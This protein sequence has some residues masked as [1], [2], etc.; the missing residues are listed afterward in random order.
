MP[1]F[2]PE[3]LASL[4]SLL[5]QNCVSS[6]SNDLCLMAQSLHTIATICSAEDLITFVS[7][8]TVIDLLK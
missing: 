2:L 3:K 6:G 5:K 1:P 4:F 7:F 8:E